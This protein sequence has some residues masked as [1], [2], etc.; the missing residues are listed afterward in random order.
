M[1]SVVSIPASVTKKS[2]PF[3]RPPLGL[4]P[5]RLTILMAKQQ[6]CLRLERRAALES[7]DNWVI[8]NVDAAGW[9]STYLNSPVAPTEAAEIP[10][11]RDPEIYI[12]RM[13]VVIPSAVGVTTT[14][15]RSPLVI[16]RKFEGFLDQDDVLRWVHHFSPGETYHF[17]HERGFLAE[18]LCGQTNIFVESVP[19][20]YSQQ[21]IFLVLN[22]SRKRN[23]SSAMIT[24]ARAAASSEFTGSLNNLDNTFVKRWILIKANLAGVEKEQDSESPQIYNLYISATIV[25]QLDVPASSRTSP[26]AV[27]DQYI[28]LDP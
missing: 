27:L 7:L 5:P 2:K 12:L 6:K 28:D 15:Q 24:W 4:F 22:G 13:K 20:A 18:I 17:A 10:V 1:K 9:V 23:I 26:H 8:L 11:F 14:N 19:S 25:P 16:L 21:A 3:C